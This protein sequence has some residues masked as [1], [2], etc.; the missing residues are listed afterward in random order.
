MQTLQFTHI[1][2]DL[3]SDL[4]IDQPHSPER[5]TFVRG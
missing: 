3:S 2:T 5:L 1:Y 4:H